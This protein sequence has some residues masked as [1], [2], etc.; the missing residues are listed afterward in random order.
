MKVE[1]DYSIEQFLLEEIQNKLGDG[2]R[3]GIHQS[4]LLSPKKAYW[5]RV[6]PLRATKEEIIYW[7]SG[8]AHESLF[9]HVSDLQHGKAKK[10]EDIWYTPDVFYNFPVEL[11]TTRR[12]FVVKEGK[13]AEQ[14]AH[15][16]KQLRYYCASENIAQGWLIVWYLVM[17][18]ENRRQTTPDYFAYR[19]EFEQVELDKTREEMLFLRNGLI[20]SIFDKD[21]SGLPDCEDWMCFK[22]FQKILVKPKCITCKGR[23]FKTEWG[24]NKH[25]DSKTGKGHTIEHGIYET[26]I[27]PKCKYGQWCKPDIYITYQDWKKANEMIDEEKQEEDL[28][29]GGE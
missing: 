17:L 23:E 8:H 12:G 28:F 20:K 26:V 19:V 22:K 9:L 16:L 27:E 29:V 18:D 11:K 2:V 24:I 13:E 1:R 25:V 5:Q 7:L 21:A 6:K 3:D 14:Y 4:D 10:W 15:Y